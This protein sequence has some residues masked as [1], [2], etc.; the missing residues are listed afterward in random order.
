MSKPSK[1]DDEDDVP[2][3]PQG[4]CLIPQL[5]MFQILEQMR[6]AYHQRPCPPLRKSLRNL[7]YYAGDHETGSSD[8]SGHASSML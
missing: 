5:S 3:P 1:P 4:Y 6:K 2:L 8:G 7:E